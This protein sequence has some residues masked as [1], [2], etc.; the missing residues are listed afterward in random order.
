M[1]TSN[2]VLIGFLA[3]TVVAIAVAFIAI[4]LA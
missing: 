2:K 1:R 3:A 4:V